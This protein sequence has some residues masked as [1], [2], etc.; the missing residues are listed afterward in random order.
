MILYHFT[1]AE[2]LDGIAARGLV[3]AIGT[4]AKTKVLTLGTPV[5]WFTSNAAPLWTVGLG[6]STE[7]WMLTVD[8][9]R[10]HLHHWRTW[11]ANMESDGIDENSNL[12]LRRNGNPRGHEPRSRIWS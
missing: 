6:Y 5:V 11:L 4:D 12:S 1:G 8:L 3:P 2:N 10:R 7:M 9:K